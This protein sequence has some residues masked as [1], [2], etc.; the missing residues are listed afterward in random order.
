MRK[1]M[2]DRLFAEKILSE[3]N[4]FMLDRETLNP[5]NSLL[6]GTDNFLFAKRVMTN[7]CL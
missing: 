6:T 4:N 3:N 2:P 1:A 5:E 7:A